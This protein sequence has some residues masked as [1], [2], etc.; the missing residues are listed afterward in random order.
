VFWSDLLT[1]GMASAAAG[2][3]AEVL[4]AL[5]DL[6]WAGE[7]T[8]DS[9]APLR[10]AVG[11]GTGPRRGGT[12]GRGGRPRLARLTRVV[13][14]AGAGRW[15]LV[16]PLLSPAPAPTAAM[17]AR[18]LQLLERLGVATRE[19]VLAE[20]LAGGFSA[21]YPVLKVL[22]ERGQARRGYFVAGLGA[23]QFALPGAVERLRDARQGEGD[24]AVAVLLS[25]TDPAQ[26]YGAALAWPETRGAGRPARNASASVVLVDGA[27]AAW[28]DRRG[29][30]VVTFAAAED[31]D[32]WL[33]ALVSQVKDGRV[34]SV[35]VRKID[36]EAVASLPPAGAVI[37][38]R[39]VAAGFVHG[40]RG[41]VLRG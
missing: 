27:P 33:S 18:A 39:L 6:V 15:S 9:F 8:N 30:H 35:E 17:H 16:A 22:E 19:A 12:G 23:A 38:E 14:P 25:A 34:R 31:D 36:G 40:Y 13:P 2:S 4:A 24:E 41:L 26:P 32:R 3:D 10:A 1:A 7:V 21:V 20:G 11:H 28:F 37:A 29:H 5:W